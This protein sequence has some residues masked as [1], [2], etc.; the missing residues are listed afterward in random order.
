MLHVQ[1]VILYHL[2]DYAHA[3][4]VLEPLFQ[5]IGPIEEVLCILLILFTLPTIFFFFL[6]QAMGVM[7]TTAFHI[8]LLL[9][10]TALSSQDAKKALVS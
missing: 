10:D 8:C 6:S 5:N 9:L 3:L 1:A 4:S 7:Q 2:H